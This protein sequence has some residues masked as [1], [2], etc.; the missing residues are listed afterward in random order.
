MGRPT[1]DLLLGLGPTTSPLLRDPSRLVFRALTYWPARVCDCS[2]KAVRVGGL[3][4]LCQNVSLSRISP[5]PSRPTA[6]F[7]RET[8]SDRADAKALPSTFPKTEQGS[9]PVHYLASLLRLVVGVSNRRKPL[10][11]KG[12]LKEL[13]MGF[14]PMTSSLPRTRSAN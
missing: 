3:R 1:K 8:P 10:C 2:S 14:G 11:D 7:F 5:N 9:V 13:L 12:F 4:H 6:L